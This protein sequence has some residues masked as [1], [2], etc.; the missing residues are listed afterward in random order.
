MRE[1]AP[2]CAT[3]LSELPERLVP[4]GLGVQCGEVQ[5]LHARRQL[6]TAVGVDA[7]DQVPVAQQHAA[8]S[9]QW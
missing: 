5:P 7:E 3:H 9:A 8:R 2:I 4:L 1:T 6:V